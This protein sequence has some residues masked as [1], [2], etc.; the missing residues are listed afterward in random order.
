MNI[1]E[2]FQEIRKRKNISVYRLAKISGISENHIHNIEKDI[3]QP[4]LYVL[5]KLLEPMGITITEFLNGDLQTYYPSDFERELLESVRAL[6][7]EQ[8]RIV[9]ELIKKMNSNQK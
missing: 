2:K 8:A 5:K 6:T 7:D 4:S 3:S 9:L 1:S